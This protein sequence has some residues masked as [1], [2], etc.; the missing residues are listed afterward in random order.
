MI[1]KNIIIHHSLT[2]D[3]QTV[4]WSAIRRYHIEE[5]GWTDIGY[6]YGLELIGDHYEVLMGRPENTA[7]AHCAGRNAES[8]G[9]CFVGNYDLAPP[10]DAMM[11]RAVEVFYPI[12]RRLA[13]PPENVFGHRVFS[14]KTCPGAQFPLERFRDALRCGLWS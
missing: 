5:N 1:P 11:R 6:H 4:S 7:G 2:K 12:M 14:Q 10:P 3:S 8:L 13:I 9:I